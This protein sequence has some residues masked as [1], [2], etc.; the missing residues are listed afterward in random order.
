M[1][2]PRTMDPARQP[3]FRRPGRVPRGGYPRND[4]QHMNAGQNV[5]IGVQIIRVLQQPG[6]D[7]LVLHHR[8]AQVLPLGPRAQNTVAVV[9]VIIM[10]HIYRRKPSASLTIR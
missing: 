9:K 7:V 3:H 1:T 2:A 6:G 8:R 5:G 4:P 10:V